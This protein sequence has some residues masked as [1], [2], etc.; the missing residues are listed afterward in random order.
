MNSL[1]TDPDATL[2]RRLKRGD[3][4]AFEDLYAQYA[5]R[6]YRQAIRML[7]NAH[8]AEEVLQEVLITVYKKIKTFRGAAAFAT[9]LYRLTANAAI[10][11]LRKRKR[12]REVDLEDYLPEFDENGHYKV[13]PIVDWSQNLEAKLMNDEAQQVLRGALD[14]LPPTDKAVVVLSD[15]ES[16]SNKEIAKILGLTVPAVKAR[17]HRSRLFLRGKIAVQLGRS[18]A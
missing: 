9:W 6:L 7:N 17:L 15:L 18:G 16:V 13:R 8:E 10:T 14:E 4:D 1:P 11:K 12:N 5:Q 3:P 2:V